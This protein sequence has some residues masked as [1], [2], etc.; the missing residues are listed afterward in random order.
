MA[1]ANARAAFRN[2]NNTNWI[3]RWL[4]IVTKVLKALLWP[5]QKI[6]AVLFPFNETDGLSSAVTAKAAEQF[7]SY[8]RSLTDNMDTS[9]QITAAWSAVGFAAAKQEAVGT[10]SLLLVYLHSP[11][12]SESRKF[13]VRTLNTDPLLSW[14]QQDR[15]LATGLSIHT[16]QGAQLQSML[17]VTSFPA[18]AVLQPSGSSLQLVLKAQGILHCSNLIPLLQ[19]VQQR[20]QL[21]LTEAE[22]RRLR[23]QQESDLRRQ[24]DE[25]YHATLRADQER[26]RQLQEER[27]AAIA[28][29]AAEEEARRQEEEAAANELERAKSLIRPEPSSG[30]TMVR[31]CL[32]NGSK[33]NRRFESTQ[34]VAALKAFLRLHCND[35]EIAMGTI[36]LSTNFPRK[37]YNEDSDNDKTLEEAELVPQAVLMVLDLDA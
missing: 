7:V 27:E 22:A 8:L 30:G 1:Q 36:G 2:N 24:Q 6:T 13:C 19:A 21:A 10:Q 33:I 16:A 23:R 29:A 18:I 15:I 37:T 31:F 25:E 3:L 5:M 14:L 26:E 28:A 20:H 9:N 34:T 11:L 17:D 12:H 4:E 35:N 32:P